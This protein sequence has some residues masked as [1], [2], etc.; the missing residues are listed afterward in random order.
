MAYSTAGS[1]AENRTGG[2]VINMIPRIGG[3]QLKVSSVLTF[4]NDSMQASNIDDALR[5]RGFTL[6]GGL[7]HLY[8]ANVS[9]GGPIMRDRVWFYGSTRKWA[10]FNKLP[11]ITQQGRVPDDR[12]HAVRGLHRAGPPRSSGTRGSRWSYRLAT[13]GTAPA[14]TSSSSTARRRRS[15]PTPTGRTCV[16]LRSTTTLSSTLLLEAGY[17]RNFWHAELQ[18]PPMRAS[19]H[20]LRRLQSVRAG[21]RLR[22]HPELRLW[23]LD[24]RWNG[25]PSGFSTYDMPSDVLMASLSWVT[26]AHNVKV[27]VT[28][29]HGDV[30]IDTGQN[31][32]SIEQ[33]YRNGVPVFGQ[34]QRHA[35]RQA[36]RA[37][38]GTSACTCRIPGRGD[39]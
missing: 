17:T 36:D 32:G 16:Q 33:R 25:P 15:T 28:Y 21:H 13:R 35:N 31:N 9:V 14:S 4:A 27:G 11:G 22:R 7:D 1:N 18:Y 38:R 8:D 5:A 20:V 19:G 24:W 2:V 34:H 3:N 12:R 10:N 6:E 23:S 30:N 37:R 39:G 29:S 26:G